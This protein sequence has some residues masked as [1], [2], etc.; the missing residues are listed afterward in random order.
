MGSLR[1]IPIGCPDDFHLKDPF[2]QQISF[3]IKLASLTIVTQGL[4]VY[5]I[6]QM[7]K[8]KRKFLTVVFPDEQD[9]MRGRNLCP[10]RAFW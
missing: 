8:S 4:Q 7:K 1:V 3:K 10:S 6:G 2:V 5:L 9:Q